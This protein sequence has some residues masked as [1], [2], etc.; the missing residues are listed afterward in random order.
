MCGFG[1]I[2]NAPTTVHRERLEAI[3]RCV[4]HR[5]PDATRMVFLTAGG[6]RNRDAGSSAFFFNR[7]AII[8][9]D[10]R[11]HQP[12]E[13]EHCVLLFNGE[14]YNFKTL[15]EEL[16]KSG[17]PFHTTSDTEVLFH[18]IKAWGVKALTRINGMFSFFWF[19]RRN[20]SF[21]MAR[22][23]LGIKPL[24]Y[25]REG[26]SFVF[27]SEL[28]TVIRLSQQ[29]PSISTR[30]VQDYLRLQYI[31]TPD[32][33][34]EGLH[35]LP[36]GHFITGD[37]QDLRGQ[38]HP[39]PV[40][41]WN[42]YHVIDEK[43]DTPA[44][45]ASLE[46]LLVESV[47]LQLQADVPL[48][49]FLSSGVDSSL[50]TALINKHFK[51]K[52]FDF[53]TV[54]FEEHTSSD[55]SVQAERYLK[56]FHNP[57]LRH[58]TLQLDSS[59]IASRL[60]HLYRFFDEPFGDPA[61]LL[62]WAISEKAR[63]HVTVVLSGDGA[64]ELFWGYPRY[65][66]WKTEST[67]IYKQLPGLALPAPLIKRLPPS[68]VK[69]TMLDMLER[70]PAQIYFNILSPRR[71]GFLP[72]VLK[73]KGRWFLEDF[74]RIRERKDFP[75]IVD[76]KTYLADAM[77][78]KVDRASMATGLEVRVPY[79]DNNIVDFALRLPWARK[80][81]REYRTKAPLKSLL[82]TLA[83]HY[84]IHQPKKGF[85][86]PL[87]KWLRGDWKPM[88]MDLA[89]KER[90]EKLGLTAQPFL[91]IVDAFYSKGATCTM[92]IWYLLNLLLWH[93][94]FNTQSKP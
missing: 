37:L 25:K 23:R 45:D 87:E 27:G 84:D 35:K 51:G 32:T 4:S 77:L 24:Y 39:A 60:N 94:H 20:Q 48:G 72:S 54:S 57:L 61:A 74:D 49:L 22:D 29:L 16:E 15:R 34:F 81:T 56:G 2:V 31:P 53:F 75:G 93:Y 71:F 59:S 76:I 64:D 83:P 42:A 46:Q 38:R 52:T 33:I 13:D 12:F 78:Y 8:D 68:W 26:E 86:F 19:D 63:E 62:N 80:S 36:P 89:R 90:L 82:A 10:P 85:S 79:L 1:G 55:E 65:N 47:R 30:S 7:L 43:P 3:A 14:I 70:D 67:R 17:A 73:G 50:L 91:D 66:Q 21:M 18:A 9:L 11:S 58:H 28:N 41:Y 92:E 40:A 88:V 6:E 44:E 69:Y 5:G